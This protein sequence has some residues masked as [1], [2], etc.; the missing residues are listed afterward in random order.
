FLFGQ[1]LTLFK[2][3]QTRLENDIVLEVEHAL[4][5]LQRHVEHQPDARWQRLQE[6]DVGD[7]RS[8]LDM[9]HAVAPYFLH[10][11]FDAAFL[12]DDALVL[13]ALVLAA[14]ALIV[15]HR[16]ENARAEQS[17][18]L[19]LEGAIVDGLRLFNF[20]VR[21]PQDLIRARKRNANPVKG[22]D[23]LPLLEDA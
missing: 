18:A 8:E 13:H 6:P 7:G 19:R 5:I 22:R 20:A 23:F 15:L 14:Q 2:R 3:G 10:G 9:A 16:P 4:E 12:A 11:H 17:V 1:E 21:P